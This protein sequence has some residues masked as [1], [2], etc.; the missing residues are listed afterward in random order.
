MR[1]KADMEKQKNIDIIIENAR[2]NKDELPDYLKRDRL[3]Y[4]LLIVPTVTDYSYLKKKK[5]P[6]LVE[7]QRRT[8]ID[9]RHLNSFREDIED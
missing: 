4:N 2:N 8:S 3:S 5:V 1:Q 9:T 6:S 7:N